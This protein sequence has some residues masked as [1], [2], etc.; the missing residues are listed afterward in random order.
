MIMQDGKGTLYFVKPQATPKTR[1]QMRED[2]PSGIVQMDSMLGRTFTYRFIA[3]A[4]M[5]AVAA[6]AAIN[7]M[8]PPGW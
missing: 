2:S 1:Q 4:A 8:L 5:V 6:L 7:M 3:T